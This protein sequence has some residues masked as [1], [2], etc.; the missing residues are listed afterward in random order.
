MS[1]HT[2]WIITRLHFRHNVTACKDITL[3]SK[4]ICLDI[5]T[6]TSGQRHRC[7]LDCIVVA[8]RNKRQDLSQIESR[9][10]KIN[11]VDSAIDILY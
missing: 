11:A 10:R 3:L 8:E 2:G 4:R 9:W 6:K 7:G 5:S 1:L